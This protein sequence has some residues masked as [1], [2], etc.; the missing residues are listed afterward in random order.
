MKEGWPHLKA[1]PGGH[2]LLLLLGVNPWHFRLLPLDGDNCFPGFILVQLV[3]ASISVSDLKGTHL[4]RQSVF[5]CGVYI[6]SPLHS[7]D[8][9]TIYIIRISGKAF[10]ISTG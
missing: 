7:I 4:H 6:V 2:R 3:F 1:Y 10:A 9:A 8:G 5:H